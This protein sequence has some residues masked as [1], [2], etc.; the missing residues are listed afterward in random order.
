MKSRKEQK[1]KKKRKEQCNIVKML[2]AYTQ[3]TLSE[4][5][6]IKAEEVMRNEGYFFFFFV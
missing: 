4:V 1:R 3:H 2:K 5:K 6:K